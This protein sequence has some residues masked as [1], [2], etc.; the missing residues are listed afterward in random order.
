M[1]LKRHIEATKLEEK[2]KFKELSSAKS[3]FH[4]TIPAFWKDSLLQEIYRDLQVNTEKVKR[5]LDNK[6]HTYMRVCVCVCVTYIYIY[7][8]IMVYS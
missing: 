6:I 3:I 5:K 2:K 8:Y 1:M 4:R 7:I